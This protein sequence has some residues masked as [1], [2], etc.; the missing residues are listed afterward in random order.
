MS[1]SATPHSHLRDL[2]VTFTPDDIDISTS[3]KNVT[4]NYLRLEISTSTDR[5]NLRSVKI[6]YINDGSRPVR[7]NEELSDEIIFRGLT[8]SMKGD[9]ESL[10]E[11][12]T[13]YA[14]TLPKD[15][16][17][18][19][20]KE[21]SKFIVDGTVLDGLTAGIASYL[22]FMLLVEHSTFAN[23]MPFQFTTPN[24]A[25]SGNSVN[26][27][28]LQYAGL[29]L[30]ALS[31]TADG[32]LLQL[33]TFVQSFINIWSPMFTQGPVI[34]GNNEL[35]LA[36]DIISGYSDHVTKILT[37]TKAAN[38]GLQAAADKTVRDMETKLTQMMAKIQRDTNNLL[39]TTR[40]TTESLREEITK[41]QGRMLDDE[42]IR[43]INAAVVTELGRG[44]HP[45][46][47][48]T[49]QPPRTGAPST[50]PKFNIKGFTRK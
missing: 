16:I 1:L 8:L 40:E 47:R 49:S 12:A 23:Q 33:V 17:A 43:H 36:L 39:A 10:A 44:H 20:L 35:R 30:S 5:S 24:S 19:I 6:R 28:M 45:T 4:G 25:R 48:V 32:I 9:A 15:D 50:Q 46:V 21:Y 3:T 42:I 26:Y 37:E 11:K 41:T 38:E 18:A 7:I 2:I 13:V 27:N 14:N 22:A 31:R 34:G 29:P